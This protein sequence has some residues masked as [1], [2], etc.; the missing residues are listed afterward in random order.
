MYC[1]EQEVSHQVSASPKYLAWMPD[2]CPHTQFSSAD[3]AENV[4]AGKSG[5]RLDSLV[6]G[7][8]TM[9]DNPKLSFTLFESPFHPH[10]IGAEPM[11][12]RDIVEL[13]RA[14]SRMPYEAKSDAP[15]W[16]MVRYQGNYRCR[17]NAEEAGGVLLDFDANASLSEICVPIRDYELE[18]LVFTSASHR[19]DGQTDK[20]RLV[21]PTATMFPAKNYPA[22]WDSIDAA[23][24]AVSDN[25]KDNT[26]AHFY[27][28][29]EYVG[30]AGEFHHFEGIILSDAEWRYVKPVHLPRTR[31]RRPE[32]M[33]SKMRKE[34]SHRA[35][36]RSSNRRK[37]RDIPL[38]SDKARAD[39]LNAVGEERY[40]ARWRLF[41][42]VAG[43]A[44]AS[45]QVI[46]E[47]DLI[48]IYDE[49][50]HLHFE[51]PRHQSPEKRR[52]LV[53]DVERV[54][55]EM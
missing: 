36:V 30:V 24:G 4:R 45:G 40:H 22:T 16:N 13:L 14:A 10:A 23:F 8:Q 44:R 55:R 49:L 19:K 50:D 29:G 39:Y 51:G 26:D 17:A 48:R 25:S 54:I 2:L 33:L 53:R 37:H 43:R 32:T 5:S 41:R 27:V 15:L 52:A 35:R 28:P 18:A 6:K 3:G 11:H 38:V 47:Q 42:S 1:T 12:W 21:I 9:P 34:A 20:F 7:H 46:S 31:N